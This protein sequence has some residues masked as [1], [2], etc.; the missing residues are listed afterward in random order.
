MDKRPNK[1][2][3]EGQKN[4]LITKIKQ[5]TKLKWNLENVPRKFLQNFLGSI[6]NSDVTAIAAFAFLNNAKLHDIREILEIING[7]KANSI[8]KETFTKIS[9]KL[10]TI[11]SK[12]S[13]YMSVLGLW[14]DE[15][16]LAALDK[17]EQSPKPN[18]P[19]YYSFELMSRT[20]KYVTGD[21]YESGSKH[22]NKANEMAE[23]NCQV[24]FLEIQMSDVMKH[25]HVIQIMQD[26]KVKKLISIAYTPGIGITTTS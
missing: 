6:R 10:A 24:K 23:N 11:N 2:I 8:N 16:I 3:S 17:E 15:K 25:K 26:D 9:R 7:E 13:E 20:I 19:N 4:N 5:N 14:E 1:N 12:V 22:K 21:A 18:P